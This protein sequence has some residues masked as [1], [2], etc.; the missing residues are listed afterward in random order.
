MEVVHAGE[1]LIS[2]AVSG[3]VAQAVIYPL[4]VIQTRLAA[5][6]GVYKGM[7]DAMATMWRREG[8]RVFY[9][10]PLAPEAASRYQSVAA[11]ESTE[12]RGWRAQGNDA[13]PD[14]DRAVCWAGH[15]QLRDVKGVADGA[16]RR[17]AA[18]SPASCVWHALFL[19]SA[20]VL[21]PLWLHSHAHAGQPPGLAPPPQRISPT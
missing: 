16:A 14:R 6:H 11:A 3:A 17:A 1:R 9:R 18:A 19:R 8:W 13:L 12:A 5:T 7:L 15:H 4:E 20:D 10:S 21:L 2:G